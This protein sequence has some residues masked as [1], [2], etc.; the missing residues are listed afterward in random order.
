MLL[1]LD[2]VFQ[3]LHV[4]ESGL[5]LLLVSF[6]LLNILIYRLVLSFQLLLILAIHHQFLSLQRLYLRVKLLLV[7]D[8]AFL[9]GEFSLTDSSEVFGRFNVIFFKL[10]VLLLSLGIL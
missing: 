9:R 2:H 1:D 8:A 5:S 7:L 3:I 10:P 4:S 6:Q